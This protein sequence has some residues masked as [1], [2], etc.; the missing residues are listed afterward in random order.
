MLD[1]NRQESIL[2]DISYLLYGN[3]V[4]PEENKNRIEVIVKLVYQR[5]S[6][7]MPKGIAFPSDLDYIITEVA[8]S[9]FNRIGSEGMTSE[10]QQD[11]SAS[12]IDN[13][14]Q[15]YKMDIEDWLKDNG[16]DERRGVVRFI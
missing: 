12:F 4:I 13:D 7:L 11:W 3:E 2:K 8:V 5:V 6:R 10:S 14:L 15:S 1:L 9:R 16:Y